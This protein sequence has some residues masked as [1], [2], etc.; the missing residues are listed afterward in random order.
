MLV[1]LLLTQRKKI[2][3]PI[4]AI[5]FL[6]Q[7]R[8]TLW[9]SKVISHRMLYCSSV[10]MLMSP[11]ADHYNASSFHS[12]RLLTTI[13]MRENHV[14]WLLV[15]IRNNKASWTSQSNTQILKM[16]FLSNLDYGS[17]FLYLLATLLVIT[18]PSF[19]PFYI[20]MNVWLNK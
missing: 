17:C 18:F 12:S 16:I 5:D 7:I 11:G 15:T 19:L 8:F 1:I 14:S 6:A 9:T 13:E 20:C 4:R 3:R 10:A 2:F